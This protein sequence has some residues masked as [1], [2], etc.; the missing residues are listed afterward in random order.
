MDINTVT[1]ISNIIYIVLEESVGVP[2]GCTSDSF[3]ALT[4]TSHRS[5]RPITRQLIPA[6]HRPVYSGQ[7]QASLFQPITGQLI[8]AN[9]RQHTPSQ[10]FCSGYCSLRALYNTVPSSN[11]N[12]G[13]P[14][15]NTVVVRHATLRYPALVTPTWSYTITQEAPDSPQGGHIYRAAVRLP[16]F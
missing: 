13:Y 8:P 11:W 7:S 1:Y 6:N 10:K 9:H 3:R 2:H 14:R 16:P 5:V 15:W 12:K 4:Q